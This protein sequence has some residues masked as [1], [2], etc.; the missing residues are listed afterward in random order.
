V[1]LAAEGL[2]NN[3]TARRLGLS[4][5]SVDL[6]RKRYLDHGVKS[7]NDELKPG[8]PRTISDEKVALFVRKTLDT[9]PKDGTHWTVR[10]I[11]QETRMSHA[12]VH[13][14]WQAFGLQPHRQEH[15][16][17]SNDPFFVENNRGYRWSVCQF[18]GERHSARRRG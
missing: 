17:I 1:L 8:R 7:L 18:S 11:A 3:L 13:R 4:S 6:W 9:K 16:K 10:S 2:P 5:H 14:I 15:L 12:I